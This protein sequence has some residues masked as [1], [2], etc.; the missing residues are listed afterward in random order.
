M[1]RLFD[2]N[3]QGNG[4]GSPKTAFTVRLGRFTAQLA[5]RPRPVIL[6]AV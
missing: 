4:N 6:F 5:L 1:A 3:T 2:A